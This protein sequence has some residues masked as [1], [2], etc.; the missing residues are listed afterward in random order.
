MPNWNTR[1]IK[2]KERN[3]TEYTRAV[4]HYQLVLYLHDRNPRNGMG[5]KKYLSNGIEI[6]KINDRH[7]TWGARIS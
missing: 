3:R 4:G 5:Q 2:K 6:S 1:I 7:Q